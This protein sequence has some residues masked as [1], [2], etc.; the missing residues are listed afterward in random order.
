MQTEFYW[1]EDPNGST[2]PQQRT[3]NL[4]YS[5]NVK[6]TQECF[7]S[8]IFDSSARY[9]LAIRYSLSRDNDLKHFQNWN[10]IFGIIGP[11]ASPGTTY[12][13]VALSKKSST[14]LT[15]K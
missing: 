9:V 8:S 4:V 13:F 11:V 14:L 10:C 6:M 5:K 3:S 12:L 15:S 7:S 2:L 1:H